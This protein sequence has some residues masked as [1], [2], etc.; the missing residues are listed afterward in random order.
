MVATVVLVVMDMARMELAVDLAVKEVQT[1]LVATATKMVAVVEELLDIQVMD[2]KEITIL[3][4]QENTVQ[5]VVVEQ[6]C[7]EEQEQVVEVENT[8]QVDGEVVDL[9]HRVVQQQ[10]IFKEVVAKLVLVLSTVVEEVEEKKPI[11][12]IM[13]VHQAL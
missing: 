11:K 6:E 1:T 3:T 10:Q 2:S 7:M 9:E 8:E 12:Q 5:Q 4:P 13:M